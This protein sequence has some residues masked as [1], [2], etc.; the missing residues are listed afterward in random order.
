MVD[1]PINIVWLK[2][3]IRT[4][5]HAPLH[6]AEKAGIPYRIIYL[7]EPDMIAYPDTSDRHLQFIYHSILDFNQ[8]L[9]S[10]NRH[11]EV[12]HGKAQEVFEYLSSQETI[13]QVFS[14]R[15]SGIKITWRRDK[16]VAELLNQQHIQWTEFKRDGIERGIKNREGWDKQWYVTMSQAQVVNQYSTNI[17]SPLD[18]PFPLTD[19]L[20]ETI[21]QYPDSYQPAGETNAWKYLRSFTEGRGNN[22]HRL[23]S[24]PLESRT[25]CGRLSP[26][27]AWGNLSIKQAVQHIKTHSNYA[28]N[29]RAFNGILTR[30]KWHCHFIQKFE[31]EC[32]YETDCINRGYELLE[33]PQNEAF[34]TAWKEGKTGFPLVDACMRCL[35]ATGWINFRM[36]AMVVSILCHH[37]DQ[38]WRTGVY[39]LANLFLDYEPGIHYPQFQ[40]QAGTTGVNTVRM[41]NPVKQSQEHDPEGKFIKQWVPEL[42]EVPVEFIHEPWKLTEMDKVFNGLHLTTKYPA[43]LVDLTESGKIARA[44]IWGHRKHPAV[45]AEKKRIVKTHTRNN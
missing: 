20:K 26:Y 10:Y 43:P 41:Y 4:Q 16:R 23:I 36:R 37:L 14:H 33:R 18:H 31:V 1:R 39:H 42:R 2:R 9:T 11:A 40:M 3:D 45:Q 32:E 6:A 8:H 30:M 34:I 28:L 27:L 25:S 44:K 15:E 29:K 22:Y 12:F 24:K 17:L 7:F 38:D 19:A 21:S 35:K 5:D 13:Q